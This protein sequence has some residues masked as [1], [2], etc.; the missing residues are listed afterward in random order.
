MVLYGDG[1]QYIYF[2][3]CSNK[4]YC[5]S[6]KKKKNIYIYIYGCLSHIDYACLVFL[7]YKPSLLL[8]ELVGMTIVTRPNKQQGQVWVFKIKPEAGLS[9]VRVLAIP[10]PNLNLDQTCL[11]LKLPKKNL[12]YIYT[13]INLLSFHS[14]TLAAPHPLFFP[15][16][17]HSQALTHC[18]RQWRRHVQVRVFPGTP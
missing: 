5:F 14:S 15:T 12:I 8:Q 18:R 13:L 7:I 11:K 17:T 2:R 10:T 9:R 6:K 1:H 16:L 4:Y 3:L